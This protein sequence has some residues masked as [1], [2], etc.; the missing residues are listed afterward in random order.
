M[1]EE[2]YVKI[3]TNPGV[4]K[5]CLSLLSFRNKKVNDKSIGNTKSQ[6]LEYGCTYLDDLNGILSFA[7]Q[8]SKK[9][10]SD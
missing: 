9:I 1:C 4:L 7:V 6:S 5:H 8:K 2:V 3:N 10:Y